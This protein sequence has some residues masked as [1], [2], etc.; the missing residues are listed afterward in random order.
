MSAIANSHFIEIKS[1]SFA[2]GW[3]PDGEP[4]YGPSEYYVWLR[5]LH[6][7][8]DLQWF[9]AS[10]D[11]ALEIAAAH[12]AKANLLIHDRVRQHPAPLVPCA[13]W[14]VH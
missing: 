3:T 12:A 11:V 8:S 7:D 4:I 14:T 10:P 6:G 13:R 5:D 1:C 2:Q 9:G